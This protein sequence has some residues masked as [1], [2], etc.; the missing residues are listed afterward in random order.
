MNGADIVCHSEYADIVRD[1]DH[2]V[3]KRIL[4]LDEPLVIVWA[5]HG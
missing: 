5:R 2:D 3:Y 1:V 4:S